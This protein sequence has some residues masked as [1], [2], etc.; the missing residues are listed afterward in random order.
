MKTNVPKDSRFSEHLLEDQ[1]LPNYV[2]PPSK[3]CRRKEVLTGVVTTTMRHWEE[4]N[5]ENPY[6]NKQPFSC[7]NAGNHSAHPFVVNAYH[8][9]PFAPFLT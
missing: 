7:Q 6:H 2:K 5:G 4:P 1:Q 9:G 3:A 8:S